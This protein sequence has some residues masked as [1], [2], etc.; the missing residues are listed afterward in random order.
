MKQV[1]LSFLFFMVLFTV[2]AQSPAP[3]DPVPQ[4]DSTV[5]ELAADIGRRI[6]AVGDA[7]KIVV[8]QFFYRDALPSLGSYWAAQ[9]TEE[10]AN[11]PNRTFII[12]ADGPTGAEWIL[13]GEIIEIAATV[14]VY[15]RLI[16]ASDRSII[17][18]LHSDFERGEYM[19]DMLA[20]GGGSS[21]STGRD[22]YEPDSMDNPHVTQ[23]GASSSAPVIN[24]SLHSSD[25][26]DFFLLV[27]GE[28][29]EGS[30]VMETT[31]NTD[32]YLELYDADSREE[33]S[34]NDDGGE[35]NNARIRYTVRPGVRYIAKV[36]AYG[37]N[38]GNYGFRVYLNEQARPTPD[39]YEADDSFSTA[40]EIS[41]GTSQ[42]HT[43]TTG[44]DVD[45]VKFEITQGGRYA[46]RAR[47]VNSNRLDTYI[48]LF[49][50]RESSIDENDD[51]GE[52]YDAR[53]SRRLET[54]TY[55]LK[56]HCLDD[57]PDQPYTISIT[58]EERIQ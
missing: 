57:E 38:T 35:G 37:D 24:R 55:Y 17:V 42:Q 16:R 51:G 36:R 58:A 22:L 11:I 4:M 31:G 49:N 15:T 52:D 25:D 39:E 45:W 23:I 13:S 30:L 34:T 14:R 29:R 54:G 33:L 19:A 10:L 53:I 3:V 41:I 1:P 26:Q 8:G 2:Y 32:T 20:G 47:G 6:T 46:I 48:E 44:D 12:L 28:G 21:S 7:P 50:S 56:V 27:P 43:F 9:L 18:S 5:K 40:K